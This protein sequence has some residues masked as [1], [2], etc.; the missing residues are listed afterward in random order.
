MNSPLCSGAMVETCGMSRKPKEIVLALS[1]DERSTLSGLA[2]SRT[3]AAHHVERAGIL[4]H[5]AEGR[6]VS[7]T[8][9][10]LG[11]YRQRVTRC[12]QRVAVAGALGAI[13]DLPRAGRP[14]KITEAARDVA[15]RRG[16]RQAQR[17]WLSPRIVDAPP[18]GRACAGSWC[19]GRPR[20]PRPAGTQHGMQFLTRN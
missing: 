17:T 12:V 13:S 5:L 10:E 14:P 19:R 6:S 7:T 4:L 1:E 20:Q 8:A 3:A 9:S 15:A 18:A 11:I 16:L 2:R